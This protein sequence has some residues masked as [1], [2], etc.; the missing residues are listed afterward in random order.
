M[1]RHNAAKT[2][3]TTCISSGKHVGFSERSKQYL[4]DACTIMVIDDMDQ[5]VRSLIAV[6]IR[7]VVAF[8][9]EKPAFPRCAI[10]IGKICREV[11]P[12][13]ILVYLPV[14][15][16]KQ[17]AALEPSQEEP[18]ARMLETCLAWDF[19]SAAAVISVIRKKVATLPRTG[20]A[21]L[22]AG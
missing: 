6:G 8:V 4:L 3:P 1:L 10:V 13:T 5:P 2:H 14:L 22:Q 17:V 21:T 12:S 9:K 16:E 7:G 15:D 18:A 19:P 20:N 11:P